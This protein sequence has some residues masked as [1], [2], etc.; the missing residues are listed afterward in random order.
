MWQMVPLMG[1]LACGL[2]MV[3][4]TAA[5]IVICRLTAGHVSAR[6]GQ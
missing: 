1:V 6:G 2:V 5:L 4:L 3:A